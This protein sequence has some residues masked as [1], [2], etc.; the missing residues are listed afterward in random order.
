MMKVNIKFAVFQIF[1]FCIDASFQ[2]VFPFIE[3]PNPFCNT[4]VSE[5]F[6]GFCSKCRQCSK[7][8]PFEL[9]LEGPKTENYTMQYRDHKEDGLIGECSLNQISIGANADKLCQYA[10]NAV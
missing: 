4:N 8:H 2:K 1:A 5:Y 9:H 10:K 7:E 3:H 6:F